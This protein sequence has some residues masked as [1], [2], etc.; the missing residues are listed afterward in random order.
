MEKKE[1]LPAESEKADEVAPAEME[2]KKEVLPAESEK[3]VEVAPKWSSAKEKA[4]IAGLN[5]PVY[6]A[7]FTRHGKVLITQDLDPDFRAPSGEGREEPE[8]EVQV[9]EHTVEDAQLPPDEE[10]EEEGESACKRS[11]KV[12]VK[13]GSIS[14]T[15]ILER[16]H[17]NTSE[18]PTFPI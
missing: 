2:K 6:R 18:S 5:D 7:V 16:R 10:E 15:T 11:K 8:G 3:A 9:V 17:G 12:K 14:V 13:K 1:V 4:W